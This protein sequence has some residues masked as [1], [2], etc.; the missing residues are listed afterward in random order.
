MKAAFHCAYN[1]VQLYC[2]TIHL[3]DNYH[4]IEDKQLHLRVLERFF[5]NPKSCDS[6]VL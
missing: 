5:R 3:E 4:K 1:G 6:I 2:P